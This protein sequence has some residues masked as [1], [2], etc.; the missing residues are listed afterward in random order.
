MFLVC[1]PYAAFDIVAPR[2]GARAYRIKR[3]FRTADHM[4]ALPFYRATIYLLGILLGYVLHTCK[5]YK[6]SKVGSGKRV[7]NGE[8][9]TNGIAYRIKRAYPRS[10]SIA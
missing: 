4:Y 9:F 3:L 6:L 8:V 1:S 5:D 10:Y 7:G 2:N